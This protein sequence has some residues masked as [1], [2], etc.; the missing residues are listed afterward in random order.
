MVRVKPTAVHTDPP[1]SEMAEGEILEY[2]YNAVNDLG[3]TQA[4][5]NAEVEL[6][7][8]SDR[9]VVTGGATLDTVPIQGNSIFIRVAEV[10]RGKT[11]ELRIG[12]DHTNPRVVGE[13]TEKVH[14]IEGI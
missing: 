4:P 10:V 13:H 8:T 5:T 14:V 2:I 11:Y 9:S 3:D 7:D 1:S 12:F 6:I